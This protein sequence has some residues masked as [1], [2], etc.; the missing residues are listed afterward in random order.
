M[1]G[2]IRIILYLIDHSMII[3]INDDFTKIYQLKL[4]NF[5]C[6]LELKTKDYQLIKSNNKRIEL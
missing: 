4:I 1:T 6:E 5:S 2:F 3:K